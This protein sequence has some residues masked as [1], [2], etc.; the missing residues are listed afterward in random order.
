M[1]ESGAS[2]LCDASRAYFMILMYHGALSITVHYKLCFTELPT[3]EALTEP[4]KSCNSARRTCGGP[5]TSTTKGGGSSGARS[6]VGTAGIQIDSYACAFQEPF[7]TICFHAG[8]GM[9]HAHA[10]LAED[11]PHLQ[12]MPG[13][14]YNSSSNQNCGHRC[15]LPLSA[16]MLSEKDMEQCCSLSK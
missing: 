5:C 16:F 3:H 4:Q 6:T 10:M 9:P 8:S 12:S 7:C 14:Q 11:R 2:A 1:K 15:A 13:H